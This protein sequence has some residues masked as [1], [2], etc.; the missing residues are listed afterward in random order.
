MRKNKRSDEVEIT[1]V[2]KNPFHTVLTQLHEVAACRV[3]EER[4]RTR[5]QK[6]FAGRRV[7][8]AQDL[9]E[10]ID[11][12]GKAVVGERASYPYDYLVLAAGEPDAEERRA[13]PSFYIVGAGLTGVEMAGELAEYVPILCRAFEIGPSLVTVCDID[14]LPRAVPNLPEKLSGKIRRRLERMHVRV[15]PDAGVCTV[16]ISSSTGAAARVYR[17]QAHTVIWAAGV[18]RAEITQKAFVCGAQ[19]KSADLSDYAFKL[20][21][22]LLDRIISGPILPHGWMQLAV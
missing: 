20:D 17:E 15:L 21:I 2:D 6:I 11:Y 3:E 12:S 7:R 5:F 16:A 14:Q 8:F 19:F 1:L 4:V 18:E 9:V 13:L 22:P 10:T